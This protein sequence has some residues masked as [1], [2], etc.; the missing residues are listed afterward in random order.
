[1]PAEVAVQ[2]LGIECG[3]DLRGNPY[4]V[5]RTSQAQQS[6][7]SIIQMLKDVSW[8]EESVTISKMEKVEEEA[9]LYLA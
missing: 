7:E 1:M 5:I 2:R 9:A 3:G 8:D 6:R 4:W